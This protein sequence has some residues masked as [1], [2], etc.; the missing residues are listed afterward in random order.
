MTQWVVVV[1]P[2]A[3]QEVEVIGPFRSRKRALSACEAVEDLEARLDPDSSWA[4]TVERLQSARDVLDG[5]EERYD[6]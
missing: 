1:R 3:T 5:L 2:D 4:P 6:F